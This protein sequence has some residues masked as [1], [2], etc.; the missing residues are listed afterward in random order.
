MR[1]EV[2][3]EQNNTN[4]EGVRHEPPNLAINDDVVAKGHQCELF[5]VFKSCEPSTAFKSGEWL[6][7]FKSVEWFTVFNIYHDLM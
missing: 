3:E 4:H 6:T 7:A 2:A 5:T 1:Q